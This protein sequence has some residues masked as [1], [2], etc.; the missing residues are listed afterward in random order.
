[1]WRV[2][3]L[4][5]LSTVRCRIN[6]AV[7]RLNKFYNF[8]PPQPIGS[9]VWLDAN[10]AKDLIRQ[11]AAVR[12]HEPRSAKLLRNAAEKV[13]KGLA[14]TPLKSSGSSKGSLSDSLE[15]R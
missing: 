7:S 1:V 6:K 4:T 13:L 10:C 11:G 5:D 12:C 2:R 14:R 3:I 8:Q 15:S 9:T